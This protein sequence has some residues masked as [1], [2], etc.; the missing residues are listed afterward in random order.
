MTALPTPSRVSR[1]SSVVQVLA[2]EHWPNLATLPTTQLRIVVDL[3]L[4]TLFVLI[5]LGADMIDHPVSQ[6]TQITV[7]AFIASMLGIGAVQFIQ[8]RKTEFAP[9]MTETNASSSTTITADNKE[10]KA[11]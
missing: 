10:A 3:G 11:P 1:A 9:T 2:Q 7:G 5:C 8:K 4:A 6:G